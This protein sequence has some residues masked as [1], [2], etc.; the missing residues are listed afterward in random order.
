MQC[1]VQLAIEHTKGFQFT[2]TL[3]VGVGRWVGHWVG[4]GGGGQVG[5]GRWVV[6]NSEYSLESRKNKNQTIKETLIAEKN[7]KQ[8]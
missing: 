5:L 6:L 8:N 4:A 1:I 2:A 7:E 3:Q